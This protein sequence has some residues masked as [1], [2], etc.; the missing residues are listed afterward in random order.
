MVSLKLRACLQGG[1]GPEGIRAWCMPS[2]LPRNF[3]KVG[4]PQTVVIRKDV[5]DSTHQTKGQKR[6]C[7]RIGALSFMPQM[8]SSDFVLAMNC[9]N[10][11][12]TSAV[13]MYRWLGKNQL[14]LF[15]HTIVCIRVFMCVCKYVYRQQLQ[16][17]WHCCLPWHCRFNRMCTNLAPLLG[18]ASCWNSVPVSSQ[19]AL[20]DSCPVKVATTFC[21][22][23]F[24]PLLLFLMWEDMWYNRWGCSDITYW[25]TG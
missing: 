6:C 25:V 15:V 24:L 2:S 17:P 12:I 22:Q 23:S 16:Y 3:V 7:I 13:D 19:N 11:T 5:C 20:H 10:Y 21:C 14:A 4:L 18:R 1:H 9:H 8:R